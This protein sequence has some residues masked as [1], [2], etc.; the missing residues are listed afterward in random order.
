MAASNIK[1]VYTRS[2]SVAT[3]GTIVTV[4]RKNSEDITVAEEKDM[5]TTVNVQ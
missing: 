2:A 5:I 1:V 3:T 4:T